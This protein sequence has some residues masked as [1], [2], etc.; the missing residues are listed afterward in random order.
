MNKYR[1]ALLTTVITLFAFAT[2]TYTSCKKDPCDAYTCQNNGT[3]SGG[4]CVCPS[5]YAGVHCERLATTSVIFK[6]NS[7]ASMSIQTNNSSKMVAPGDTASFSG[8]PGE[9][10]NIYAYLTAMYLNGSNVGN[11][12]SWNLT[13]T[14]PAS[15]SVMQNM[16]VPTTYFFLKVVNTSTYTI[17]AEQVNG[18]S[19]NATIPNNAQTYG[20]G[21]YNA[22]GN[23]SVTLY[24]NSKSWNFNNLNLPY[25]VNQVA[26]VT[27]N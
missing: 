1:H 19:Y 8:I 17:T 16:D 5:Q 3:C 25:T 2:V 14:Y 21:Y 7:F 10:F 18:Y 22:S 20:L 13:L 27:A 9:T 11:T 6:N 12:V 23:P 15:G 4:N 24:A 26:T